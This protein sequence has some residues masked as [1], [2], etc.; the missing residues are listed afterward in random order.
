MI[1]YQNIKLNQKLFQKL[2]KKNREMVRIL[3]EYIASEET[4]PKNWELMVDE[5]SKNDMSNHT[6]EVTKRQI[7]KVKPQRKN[8]ENEELTLQERFNTLQ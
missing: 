6:I 1:L 4:K 5:M 8:L 2:L 3:K 7:G